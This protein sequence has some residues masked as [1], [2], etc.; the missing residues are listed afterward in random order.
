MY[1][2]FLPEDIPDWQMPFWES[3]RR[4]EPRVQRCLHCRAYRYH[5]KEICSRCQSPDAEWAAISG[6]GRVYTYAVIRRPPT[7]AYQAQ[8]PYVIAHVTMEEGFRMIG[9]LRGI[10]PSEVHIGLP[11]QIAFDDVS[12]EWTLPAFVP[13]PPNGRSQSGRR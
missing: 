12:P 8:I 11:V 5:P 2:G 3:L 7:P 1:E 10:E 4:H 9:T 6:R 13:A